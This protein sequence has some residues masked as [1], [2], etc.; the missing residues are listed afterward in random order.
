MSNFEL[1][2]RLTNDCFVL[3]EMGCSL[4]LLMNNKLV[5]W[6]ILVPK[7][8]HTYELYELDKNIQEQ[9]LEEIN[10]LSKFIKDNLEVGKLNVAAIG[11]IVK[12]L[13]IHVIART[14]TDYCWPNVV[15]GAE[16]KEPYSEDE[17]ENL[18]TRLTEKLEGFS[19]V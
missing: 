9:L 8:T 5:P 4:L 15:W 12:Q 16:G 18:V 2:P 11:N 6:F 3:G 10:A 7:V 19:K 17:V 14:E 13:H 1:D